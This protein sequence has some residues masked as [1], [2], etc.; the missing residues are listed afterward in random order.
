ML[1]DIRNEHAALEKQL[2]EKRKNM[3]DDGE[4][5]RGE[6]VRNNVFCRRLFVL[7]QL[8]RTSFSIYVFFRD[9]S[10]NAT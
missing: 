1:K 5:L 9:C 3:G 10:S 4:T 7:V 2:K 8:H 6:D